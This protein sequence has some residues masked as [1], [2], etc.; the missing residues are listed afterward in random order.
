MD[1]YRKAGNMTNHY[2]PSIKAAF[3]LDPVGRESG[4]LRVVPGSHRS[5]LH[6]QLW[7]LHLDIPARAAKLPHV[8][9]K[10][11]EM[12]ER[13]S[14]DPEGGEGLLADPKVNHFGLEPRDV[15]SFAIESQPGDVVFFSHQLWHA[16]FGG[17][18]GRRMFTLN[19]RIAEAEV[20]KQ[21]AEETEYTCT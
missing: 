18:S 9:A 19:Y 14:G 4:C 12:W 20:A 17:R 8:G 16:S 21:I 2:V 10:L 5:P 7:S 1:P 11:L 3:Y 15:P 13:D 6:E